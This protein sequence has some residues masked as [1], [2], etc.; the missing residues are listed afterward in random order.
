[1]DLWF[2]VKVPWG[3]FCHCPELLIKI[4]HSST[5]WALL[6]RLSFCFTMTDCINYPHRWRHSSKRAVAAM[7]KTRR[8]LNSL[9]TCNGQS[10]VFWQSTA[11][12]EFEMQ[13]FIPR[14]WHS[15]PVHAEGQGQHHCS[16]LSSKSR[17]MNPFL[18]LICLSDCLF[19]RFFVR[20]LAWALSSCQ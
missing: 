10:S 7:D 9:P 2:M 17:N 12:S 3:F 14:I 1:M 8:H 5:S 13:I 19:V 4:N 6:C 18:G 16:L 20:L 11:A 15:A